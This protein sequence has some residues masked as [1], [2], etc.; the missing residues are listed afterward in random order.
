M[1][2]NWVKASEISS[3]VYCRRSWWLKRKQGATSQNVRELQVGNRHHQEHGRLVWQSLWAR[4]VAYAL[5]F[6]VV[7][8]MTFQILLGT[9]K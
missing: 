5:L 4:R 9:V 6:L 1:S 8:F 7:A 3:Y 2:D